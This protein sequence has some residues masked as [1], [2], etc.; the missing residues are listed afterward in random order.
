MYCRTKNFVTVVVMATSYN[1]CISTVRILVADPPVE[2][3]V[4]C[5]R[6]S[7]A[8]DVTIMRVLAEYL[9]TNMTMVN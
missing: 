9:K 7:T 3:D 8:S 1:K 2:G 5:M 6:S 4:K